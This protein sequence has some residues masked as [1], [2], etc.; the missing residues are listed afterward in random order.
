MQPKFHAVQAELV[1][2]VSRRRKQNV[3]ATEKAGTTTRRSY[4]MCFRE[5]A[6]E[7]GVRRADA[8]AGGKRGWTP[9]EG[10]LRG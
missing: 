2:Y 6:G 4:G 10:G 3:K 5:H 7:E 9:S 1:A 8:A